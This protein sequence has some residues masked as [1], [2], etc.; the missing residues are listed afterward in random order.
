MTSRLAE[1]FRT[2]S[3]TRRSRRARA[4]RSTFV[5]ACYDAALPPLFR[6]KFLNRQLRR[7]TDLSPSLSKI[8]PRPVDYL[9]ALF[10]AKPYRVEDVSRAAHE[11]LAA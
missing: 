8:V 10:V 9:A 4:C 6:V 2:L 11:L 3:C 5:K 1:P 7:A